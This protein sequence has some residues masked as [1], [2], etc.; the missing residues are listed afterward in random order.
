MTPLAEAGAIACRQRRRRRDCRR[1]Q[2]HRAQRRAG[3][4]RHAGE[5][6]LARFAKP[7]TVIAIHSTISDTTAVELARQLQP[8]GIHIVDAPVS[9][10][11]RAAKK[12]E[13]ATMVGADRRGIRAEGE[14]GVRAVGVADRAR[15][16]AWR[17]HA[18]EAGAQ[19]VALTSRLPPRA[20]RRSSPRPRD[21]PAGSRARW[22]GTATRSRWRWLDHVPRRHETAYPG[23]L[24]ARAV[25]PRARAG[26]EGS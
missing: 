4:R 12:G 23:S 7:G 17:R 26:G 6:G 14:A 3:A 2:R 15:R 9:G 25:P 5:H 13:L 10:G 16:R 21:Q 19:H 18:D 11:G 1:H 22:C 20:R 24:P 8:E